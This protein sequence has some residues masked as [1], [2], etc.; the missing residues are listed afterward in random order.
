M[1]QTYVTGLEGS[2]HQGELRIGADRRQLNGQVESDLLV[3]ISRAVRRGVLVLL[4]SGDLGIFGRLR[5]AES[6]CQTDGGSVP[7][8]ESRVSDPL[9]HHTTWRKTYESAEDQGIRLTL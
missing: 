8:L 6:G 2:G 3:K 7:L 5:F 9:F 1:F 4:Q